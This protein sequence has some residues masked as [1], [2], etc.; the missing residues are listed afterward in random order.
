MSQWHKAEG[1][2]IEVDF[3]EKEVAVW[4]GADNQGAMYVTLTFDQIKSIHKQIMDMGS[5]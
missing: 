2:D 1:M 4:A 5:E 3:R